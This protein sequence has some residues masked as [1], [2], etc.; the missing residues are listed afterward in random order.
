MNYFKEVSTCYH[1]INGVFDKFKQQLDEYIPLG[2]SY[3]HLSYED[4]CKNLTRYR[5]DKYYSLAHDRNSDRAT[6]SV[7]SVLAYDE[8]GIRNSCQGILRSLLTTVL[9]CIE[10]NVKSNNASRNSGF[11]LK[12][13]GCQLVKPVCQLEVISRC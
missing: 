12:T 1:S 10:F 5:F 9:H 3:S 13:F 11:D 2:P 7:N 8:N 6:K 4:A